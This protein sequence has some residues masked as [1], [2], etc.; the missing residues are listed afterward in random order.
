LAQFDPGLERKVISDVLV[1]RGG[2]C[3]GLTACDER[4]SQC[5]L[6]K[7][8]LRAELAVETAVGHSGGVCQCIDTCPRY[9][10][11]ANEP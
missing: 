11:L 1:E 2:T 7:A 8:L 4:I 9:A 10:A 3:C 6:D 5:L